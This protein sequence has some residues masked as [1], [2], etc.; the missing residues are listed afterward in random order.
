[1]MAIRIL[2]DHDVREE[3]I[4]LL[5]VLMAERGV[6]SLAYA[7]PRVSLLTTAVETHLNEHVRSVLGVDDFGILT[8]LAANN[9]L[10]V[11]CDKQ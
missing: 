2:L 8:F 7:F 10:S 6:H 11:I 9:T 4:I 3:D 5:S 1:M